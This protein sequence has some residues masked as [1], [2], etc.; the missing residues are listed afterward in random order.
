MKQIEDRIGTLEVSSE[1]L[2]NLMTD[3]KYNHVTGKYFD[4]DENNRTK[5]MEE[6]HCV[7]RVKSYGDTS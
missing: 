3:S 4:R 2:A 6:K 7:H 1:A 5:I